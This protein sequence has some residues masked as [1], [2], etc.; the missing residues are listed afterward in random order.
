MRIGNSTANIFRNILI[1][2]SFYDME[3]D[4]DNFNIIDRIHTFFNEVYGEN[5][6]IDE[7]MLNV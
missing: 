1:L 3:V 5:Y 4:M 2:G 7:I 6:P